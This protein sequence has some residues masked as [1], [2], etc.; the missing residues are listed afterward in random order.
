MW[1]WDTETIYIV[2]YLTYQQLLK[3]MKVNSLQKRWSSMVL[4]VSTSL[5]K[6]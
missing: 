2:K 3:Y 6:H 5:G 4:K 1:L